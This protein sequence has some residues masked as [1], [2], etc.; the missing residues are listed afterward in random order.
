MRA[1]VRKQVKK[2]LLIFGNDHALI[3][4]YEVIAADDR[5]FPVYSGRDAMGDHILNGRMLFFMLKI[6]FKRIVYDR[7]G[8]R[9]RI[10]LLQAGRQPQHFVCV[11]SAER[12]DHLDSGGRFGQRSGLVENDCIRCR[13]RFE[14]TTALDGDMMAAAFPHSRESR[15]RNRE[16]ERTG[17]IDHQYRQRA[18]RVP[19]QKIGQN[20]SAEAVRNE[21][22]REVRSLILCR[23]LHLLAGFDHMNDPV[24]PS[25]SRALFDPDTAFALFND[26][27]GIP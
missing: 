10:M 18:G 25:A 21:F 7:T 27:T 19:G 6:L 4:E 5:L 24:I 1:V 13:D 12:N 11:P 23:R 17:E 22:V 26:R 2:F 3:L 20:G 14:E 9:M 8:D 16:F 15:D